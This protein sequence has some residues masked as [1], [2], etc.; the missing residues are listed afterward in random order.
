MPDSQTIRKG[1]LPAPPT[2]VAALAALLSASALAYVL[3][4]SSILRHLSEARDE[5]QV[6]AARIEG[7]IAFTGPAVLEAASALSGSTD[8]AELQADAALLMKIPGRCRMEVASSGGAKSAAV[9]AF[10]KRRTEGV[11]LAPVVA[12]VDQICPLLAVRSSSEAETR[13][14]V[15]KHLKALR[16]DTRS[17]SLGRMAGQV[18]YVMGATAEGQ[19]Q[20][21]IYKDVF[22]PARVRWS[23]GAG[24]LW[25]ARF[26]EYGSSVT[27]DW[28]PRVVEVYRNNELV[29]RFTGLKADAK[30][31]I[32][33][34]LF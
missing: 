31:Q 29:I 3:P 8:R 30:A 26:L 27:G 1:K 17:T 5:V 19:P 10:G 11:A 9:W 16:I 6:S 15:E 20:F 4:G 21:W 24:A 33:D 14:A 23:E 2:A 7:S 18:A 32:S 13:A 22:L 25:D 34:R 12:A 28:F